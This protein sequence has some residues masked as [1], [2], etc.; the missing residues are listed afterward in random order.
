MDNVAFSMP[1]CTSACQPVEHLGFITV[2]PEPIHFSGSWGDLV[3][4]HDQ[5]FVV[6]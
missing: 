5:I 1:I 2:Y 6:R 4:N 3:Q